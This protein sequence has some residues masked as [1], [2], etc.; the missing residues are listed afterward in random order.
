MVEMSGPRKFREILSLAY[1]R[2]NALE[3]GEKRCFGVSMSQCVALETLR[4]EGPMPVRELAQRMGLDTSTVTRLVDG[5]VRDALARRTRDEK[6]DR[7]RVFVSLT[8]EGGELAGRLE[9]CA[10]DYCERILESIPAGRR[11]DVYHALEL[12]VKA[13]DDLPATCGSRDRR[14]ETP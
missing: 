10:D 1:Q 6:G 3:R 2:F 14:E 8:E 11:E 13:I 12:L 7:R 5:L 9:C 4:R